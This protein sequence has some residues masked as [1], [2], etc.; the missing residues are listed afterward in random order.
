MWTEYWSPAAKHWVHVDSCEAESG[1]PLLYDRGWG[2]VQKWCLAF[3]P[4]GA[5]DV[6]RAYVDD[7][8]ACLA[9]RMQ[10]TE[11]GRG[12][13]EERLKTVSCRARGC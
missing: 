4:Y 9:R 12:V 6:S 2:K 1:K 8:D 10:A 13:S 5:E 3:G 11:D 7:W